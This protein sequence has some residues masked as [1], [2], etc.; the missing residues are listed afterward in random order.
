M[1]CA[2]DRV[3]A[4]GD[5]LVVGENG[6]EDGHKAIE[7][8]KRSIGATASASKFPIGSDTA[9]YIGSPGPS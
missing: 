1:A 9:E 4:G 7:Q 3:N 2:Q 6:L 8:D 5:A